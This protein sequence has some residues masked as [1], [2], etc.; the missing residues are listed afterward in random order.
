[1]SNQFNNINYSEL[2][3]LLNKP[4]NEN[5]HI[6]TLINK[7]NFTNECMTN[8]EFEEILQYIAEENIN[9]ILQF[10]KFNKCIENIIKLYIKK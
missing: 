1:M 7:I 2:Y 8:A 10:V 5:N 4:C 9:E 6:N 3:D